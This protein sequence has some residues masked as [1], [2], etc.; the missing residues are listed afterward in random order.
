MDL[1]NA[2]Q[3]MCLDDEILE[4]TQ[5][6]AFDWATEMVNVHLVGDFNYS[7]TTYDFVYQCNVD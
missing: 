3:S 5:E 4:E 7:D 2:L 1:C 6:N